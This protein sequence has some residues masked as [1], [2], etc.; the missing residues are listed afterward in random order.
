MHYVESGDPKNRLIVFLHGFPE[1]WY[2]WR[3]QIRYLQ[4]QYHILA[5]DLRGLLIIW[6]SNALYLTNQLLSNQ[7]TF[8]LP[9]N[10]YLTVKLLSNQRNFQNSFFIFK[11]SSSSFTSLVW[12]N[13]ILESLI[14][15]MFDSY[16]QSTK[17]K[18]IESD[19]VYSVLKIKLSSSFSLLT[20]E[21]AQIIEIN[22]NRL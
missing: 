2:S 1:F 12:L 11:S 20:H 5:L 18:S 3:Y 8:I 9:I 13:A 14:I 17:L 10:F 16:R 22:S 4:S 6:G 15:F 19:L 7:S 21:I